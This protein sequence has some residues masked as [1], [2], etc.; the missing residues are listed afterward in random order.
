MKQ[1]PASSGPRGAR[2]I[3]AA[4]LAAGAVGI[5]GIMLQEFGGWQ[6][7][8]GDLQF[9]MLSIAAAWVGWVALRWQHVRNLATACVMLGG[10]GLVVTFLGLVWV[11]INAR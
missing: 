3:L 9:W 10:A 1:T 11:V 2:V 5:I 4:A 7:G 6:G 8:L